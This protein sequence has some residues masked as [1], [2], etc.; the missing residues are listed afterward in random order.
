MSIFDRTIC[1]EGTNAFK[2]DFRERVFGKQDVIPL[3]VADMDFAS[4]AAVTNAL[5]NRAQHPI[6]GYTVRPSTYYKI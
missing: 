3:W 4:P 2:T 1:R 5:V 6:Y